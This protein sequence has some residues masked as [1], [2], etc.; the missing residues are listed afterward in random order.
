MNNNFNNVNDVNES[1]SKSKRFWKNFGLF[2]VA[3]LLAVVTV[4]VLS[5]N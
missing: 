2:V 4:V 5:L 3:F 1:Q